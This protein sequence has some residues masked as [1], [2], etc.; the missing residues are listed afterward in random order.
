MNYKAIIDGF[1]MHD[2]FVASIVSKK[3][4]AELENK[5]LKDVKK[6]QC[7]WCEDVRKIDFVCDSCDVV[8]CKSCTSQGF[9][10]DLLYYNDNDDRL[11]SRCY[12]T[13]YKC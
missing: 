7:S 4:G 1:N 9:G 2:F 8:L 10:A 6:A 12:N 3:S 13:E 11:C 5:T